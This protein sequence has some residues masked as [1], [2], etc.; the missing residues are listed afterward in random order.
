VDQLSEDGVPPEEG[1]EISC[2]IDG[3][4]QD[5]SGGMATVKI[6]AINGEPV[7]AESEEGSEE[8]G[9]ESGPGQGPSGPAS[10]ADGFG[11][12][13]GAAPTRPL[14]RM[15]TSRGAAPGAIMPTGE[16]LAQMGQRLRRQARNRP[17]PF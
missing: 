1:D 7:G 14:N 8:E 4:V 15:M 3:T 10:G 9:E 12:P 6:T 11:R 17:I 13:L 2:S 5:I 16:T